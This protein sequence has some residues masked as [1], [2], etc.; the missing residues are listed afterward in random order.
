MI[1]DFNNNVNLSDLEDEQERPFYE[2]MDKIA[3]VRICIIYLLFDLLIKF[4]FLYV[5][6]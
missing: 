4:S 2:L 3:E 6:Y 1:K 5:R